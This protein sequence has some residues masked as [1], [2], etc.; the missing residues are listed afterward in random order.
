[1]ATLGRWPVWRNDVP[2]E[3]SRITS[4]SIHVWCDI[5]CHIDAVSA[6]FWRCAITCTQFRKRVHER[7]ISHAVLSKLSGVEPTAESQHQLKLAIQLLH[8]GHLSNPAYEW[9]RDGELDSPS[10][11]PVKVTL[12]GP[13]KSGK[14]S[15]LTPNGADRLNAVHIHSLATSTSILG[16]SQSVFFD[17]WDSKVPISGIVAITQ[18]AAIS[19]GSSDDVDHS[20]HN[21]RFHSDIVLIVF[22]IEDDESYNNATNAFLKDVSSHLGNRAAIVLVGTTCMPEKQA[23]AS[24]CK[25]LQQV[26]QLMQ[27]STRSKCMFGFHV[28]PLNGPRRESNIGPVHLTVYGPAGVDPSS[29][30]PRRADG[31]LEKLISM[32]LQV[33]ERDSSPPE[34]A[35]PCQLC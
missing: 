24:C 23:V 26:Q 2:T 33:V 6:I 25:R 22:R 13:A 10:S 19:D 15:M 3:M 21:E 31:E 4:L 32:L 9:T 16:Y 5:V 30:T 14:S 12:V 35:L 18:P 28:C 20:Q 27:T 8:A 17:V 34:G 29:Q 11:N 7:E 1:M